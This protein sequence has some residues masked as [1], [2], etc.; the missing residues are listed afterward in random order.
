[1]TIRK[2]ADDTSSPANLADDAFERVVRLHLAPVIA[3]KGEVSQEGV[4]LPGFAR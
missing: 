3:R 1:M 4:R 2:S